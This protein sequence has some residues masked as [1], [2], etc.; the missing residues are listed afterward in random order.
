MRNARV[1]YPDTFLK[2]ADSAE[3]YVEE[4]AGKTLDEVEAEYGTIPHEFAKASL[5][6]ADRLI[7]YKEPNPYT[8]MCVPLYSF[9]LPFTIQ[10]VLKKYAKPGIDKR[11]EEIENRIKG[12]ISAY[13]QLDDFQE[14]LDRLKKAMAE[15]D[16]ET[17]MNMLFPKE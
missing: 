2:Y 17:I 16:K 5:M 3:M 7:E 10:D 11:I 8:G 9:K 13:R 6:V 12:V 4:I 14:G 15:D 1:Q